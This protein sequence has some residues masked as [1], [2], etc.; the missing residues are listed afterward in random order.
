MAGTGK[1]GSVLIIPCSAPNREFLQAIDIAMLNASFSVESSV[2]SGKF[3]KFTVRCAE[4]LAVAWRVSVAAGK[5][6]ARAVFA[7]QTV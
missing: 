2:T 7:R 4:A 6:A 1:F 5:A 3:E